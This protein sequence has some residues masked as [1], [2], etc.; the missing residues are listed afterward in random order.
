MGYRK[1]PSPSY[2]L[3]KMARRK[4]QNAPVYEGMRRLAEFSNEGYS[5]GRRLPS[6]TLWF[7]AQNLLFDRWWFPPSLR[8]ALLRLF[9]AEV[10]QG[11]LIRHGVRVHWPWRLH[12]GDHVWV[13]EG[14]WL[15]TIEDI[16]V[17]DNVCISQRAS[18]TT[19]SHD[20][21]DP[22][23]H[24]DNAPIRLRSGCWIGAE[25]MVA[26]GVTVGLNSVVGARALAYKDVPDNTLVLYPE[27]R[28]RSAGIVSPASPVPSNASDDGATEAADTAAAS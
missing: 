5:N 16:V 4:I 25:A 19:G 21:R 11:C 26:R 2:T 6:M 14:V 15:H 13:G 20:H 7:V 9:G 22:A 17:E 24:T 12:L 1:G 10:G 28:V 18:I 23:F 8:P 27:P 3:E